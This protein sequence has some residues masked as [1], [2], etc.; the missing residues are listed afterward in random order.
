MPPADKQTDVFEILD[1]R[2]SPETRFRR[3]LDDTP[4]WRA[5][6]D[7]ILNRQACGE[8]M[9]LPAELF[10]ASVDWTRSV[11]VIRA[12]STRTFAKRRR[13]CFPIP[14]GSGGASSASRPT[15]PV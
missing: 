7:S 2:F 10:R 14:A 3:L 11:K 6:A 5:L 15:P 4:E 8:P 1:R 13:Y 9:D 12:I